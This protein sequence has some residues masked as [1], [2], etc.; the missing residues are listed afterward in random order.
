MQFQG[1]QDPAMRAIQRGESPVVA[2]MPTGGG[3][4]MLFIVPAFTAPGGTTIVVVL[5]V[6]LR[7]DMMRRCQEL[8]ISCVAWESRRPPDAV[9][10]VLVMPEST[11]SPDF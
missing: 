10:I 4:S 11:V 6:V 3:K 8:G 9:S 2:V 7:A 5:L 1:V